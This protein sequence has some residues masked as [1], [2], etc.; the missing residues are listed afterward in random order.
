[1]FASSHDEDY[2]QYLAAANTGH[3]RDLGTLILIFISNKVIPQQ[4]P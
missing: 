4:L 1:M 3:S 2:N